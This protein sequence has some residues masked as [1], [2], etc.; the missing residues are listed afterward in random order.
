MSLFVAAY[1]SEDRLPLSWEIPDQR[2]VSQEGNIDLIKSGLLERII[3][4]PLTD[5][6]S[7]I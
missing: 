2:L 4:H 1:W 7:D 3:P 5:F 6:A